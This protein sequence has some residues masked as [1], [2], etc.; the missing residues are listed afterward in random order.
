MNITLHDYRTDP[1]LT[2][3]DGVNLAHENIGSLMR[4]AANEQ[5]EVVFH[6]FN[7]LLTDSDYA[8]E[9][10]DNADLVISNV[11]PH[12]HYYFYLRERYGFNY[13]ILRDVRTAIWSSYLLQE[14][15]CAPLLRPKD[16]LMVASHYTHAL[17]E[18]IFPHLKQSLV[19]RCY[20]LTVNFPQVLPPVQVQRPQSSTTVLG[21]VGR[22]SEDKNFPQIVSA[23]I[24]LN[25]RGKGHFKLLACGDIHSDSCDPAVIATNVRQALGE[26]DFFEYLPAR[27]NHAIWE[28]Y[29]S[30]DV[31]VFPST[32]NLETLGRV[33]IEAS[34]AE[35]P[36]VCGA[37]AA[38]PE[39]VPPASLCGVD[40]VLE[41][42][43]SAHGDHRLGSLD[44]ADMIDIIASKAFETPSCFSTYHNDTE[45]FLR[46]VSSPT[47]DLTENSELDDGMNLSD[48]FA[49]NSQLN[50]ADTQLQFIHSLKVTLPSPTNSAVAQQTIEQLIPWFLGLQA[51]KH[52]PQLKALHQRLLTLSRYKERTAR[53]IEKSGATG[54][55]FTNV[56]GIDIELCHI[57]K[58]YP[59]F[60]LMK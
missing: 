5:T 16:L 37:H 35:L 12:A 6:D 39:L 34:Y 25:Q 29:R 53:F 38:A 9:I 48:V 57:A 2:Q 4:T 22:L 55:D 42:T 46:V 3:K 14:Y 8:K 43:F 10:L 30:V 15:L 49:N 28:V 17:Y 27:G 56:G 47:D 7:K 54:G 36:V 24:A 1:A 44:L 45:R 23:L 20:P 11:G 60:C 40:Y 19:F 21:Y 58:F 41:K 51:P 32:S 59:S 50:L 18:K 33:L 26:G 13:R 31:L 52:S